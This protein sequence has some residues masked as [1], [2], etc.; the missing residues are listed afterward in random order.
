MLFY[1]LELPALLAAYVLLREVARTRWAAVG[2]L[3]LLT[4]HRMWPMPGISWSLLRVGLGLAALAALARFLRRGS[5][6]ALWAAGALLGLSFLFS[7]E[8]GVASAVAC[9]VALAI[10]C[11]R[12]G[13]GSLLLFVRRAFLMGVG[14]GCS[15]LPVAAWFASRGALGALI[16]NLVGFSRLRVLGHG[17]MEFPDLATR[18]REWIANSNSDTWGLLRDAIAV[19]FGPILLV[20]AMI[21]LGM[22]FLRGRRGPSIAIE[23]GLASYGAVLFVSPLTRPDLTHVIFAMP[24][25]FILVVVLV[26]R[27]IAAA[28]AGGLLADRAIAAAFA[29]ATILGLATFETDT[30]ENVGIFAR[31][32]VRNVTAR[33]TPPAEEDMRALDL[34]RSGGV[35]L[36]ADR[37]AEIEGVVRFLDRTTAPGEP[38]WCFPAEPML[39]FLADR[40]LANRYPVG[41]FAITRDQRLELLADVERRGVRRVVVNTKPIVVDGIPSRDALPELWSYVESRFEPDARFG[42]FVVMRPRPDP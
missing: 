26:E 28:R 42:R 24:P 39:N 1:L 2:G 13:D 22:G 25:V 19:V 9:G 4:F 6:S 8:A 7:P 38:V 33:G 32:L 36:P 31:Q 37:A 5:P 11:V 10:G 21:R 27:A 12:E 30:I 40:P 17:G 41:L 34:P 18:A 35:R 14:C 23:A 15:I 29:L 3:A 16:E 20:V